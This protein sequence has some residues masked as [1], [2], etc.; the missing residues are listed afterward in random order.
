MF[1]PLRFCIAGLS[2]GYRLR[3]IYLFIYLFI[4][5][6]LPLSTSPGFSSQ[7]I[8]GSVSR[9]CTS[10]QW[11]SSQRIGS[12]VPK[13]CTFVSVGIF[14]ENCKFR[15]KALHSSQ[16]VS[17]QRTTSFVSR[18]C[19]RLNVYRPRE[20]QVSSQGTALSSQW[21]SSLGTGGLV[22]KYCAF[23]L[24]EEGCM[25]VRGYGRK[26]TGGFLPRY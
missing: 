15:L 10:S 25:G 5:G 20:L 23:V 16:C 12:F 11:I 4:E 13:Y 22:L 9:H 19:I 1:S 14:P 26:V 8:G 6:L 17:S 18:H 2:S 21:A 7:G 24:N 3:V